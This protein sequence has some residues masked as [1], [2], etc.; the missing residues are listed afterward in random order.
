MGAWLVA[1]PRRAVIF[2]KASGP[3]PRATV[4]A[5][6]PPGSFGARC[7]RAILLSVQPAHRLLQ[8][9]EH[10]GGVSL[11]RTFNLR[12]NGNMSSSCRADCVARCDSR[13]SPQTSVGGRLLGR[14]HCRA[15]RERAF[16]LKIEYS[17]PEEPCQKSQKHTWKHAASKSWTLPRNV[18]PARAFTAR[19]CTT[20]VRW[21]S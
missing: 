16:V 12:Q 4:I 2:G 10:V 11:S 14:W 19:R 3:A 15:H 13:H 18:S 17:F 20:S 21:P 7:W 8:P 1:L 6:S 5:A 9:S